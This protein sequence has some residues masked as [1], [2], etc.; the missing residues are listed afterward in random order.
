MWVRHLAEGERRSLGVREGQALLSS[1]ERKQTRG[2]A[3]HMTSVTCSQDCLG[4]FDPFFIFPMTALVK[5][6]QSTQK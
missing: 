1:L 5:Q 4:P 2:P 6:E 3:S